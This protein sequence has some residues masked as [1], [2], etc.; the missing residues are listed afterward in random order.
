M[1]ERLQKVMA[2]WGIASRRACEQLIRDGHV[3]VN[4][5]SISELGLKVDPE[6]DTIQ[7]NGRSLSHV[8]PKRIVIALNKPAGYLSTCKRTS[9]K[10]PTVLDLVPAEARLFPIGRLDRESTGLLLMTND[11]ELANRIMHP[12][13][14]YDK[15]Y[16]VRVQERLST[17]QLKRLRDGVWLDDRIAKPLAVHPARVSGYTITLQEGRKR[18]VRRMVEAVGATVVELHRIRVGS[19]HLKDIPSGRWRKLTKSEVEE[20]RDYRRHGQNHNAHSE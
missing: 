1:K 18:E 16:L 9:S 13:F 8:P 5:V 15:E 6:Q 7:L 2:R 11:G 10:N 20:L 4:G 14:G 12:R 17:T 19:F 3:S